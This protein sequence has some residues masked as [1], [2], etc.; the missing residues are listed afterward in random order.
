MIW[1][2]MRLCF[3]QIICFERFINL[4]VRENYWVREME[5]LSGER[6]LNARKLRE[7]RYQ[8]YFKPD[9]YS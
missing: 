3:D 7:L 2:T 8:N 9:H 6:K 1:F 5:F 4:R